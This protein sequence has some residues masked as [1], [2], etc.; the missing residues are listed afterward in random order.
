ME[1]TSNPNYSIVEKSYKSKYICVDCRKVFKRKL[2][3]D[4]TNETNIEEKEPTCPQCKKKTQ[5]IGP[6]FRAPKM[7]NTNAWNS[8]KA[9]KEIGI[10]GSFFGWASGDSEIPESEK[11]LREK[12]LNKKE[13]YKCSIEKWVSYEYHTQNKE[14]I[15]FLSKEI[16]KIDSYLTKSKS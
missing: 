8:I 16:K 4:F 6:K 13:S 15:L 2:L 1:Y 14:N 12:L 7:D 10:L 3:S 11:A 5:W 9:L